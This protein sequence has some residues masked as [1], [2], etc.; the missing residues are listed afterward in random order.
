V[1]DDTPER[2]TRNIAYETPA[3]A[4]ATVAY[5]ITRGK[6]ETAEVVWK[7]EY[8]FN[9]LYRLRLRTGLTFSRLERSEFKAEQG[10]GFTETRGRH[11]ADGTF[12]AQFYVF[13][14]RDIRNPSLK[15]RAWPVAY[16][17]FS[18]KKPL[19]NLYIGG[20]WEPV[21]GITAI[22]GKHVGRGQALENGAVR[23]LWPSDYFA[24]I[25]FDVDFF[26]R[27]FGLRLDL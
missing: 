11:G 12:G 22:V 13:G 6:G 25:I 20:G 9:R 19:Q 14:R 5:T 23:D 4:P 7:G 24:S 27:L 15:D 26:K 17:G 1:D 21:A 16:V 18:M 8:R 3:T 2:T 10:G